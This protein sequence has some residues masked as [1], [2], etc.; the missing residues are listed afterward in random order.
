MRFVGLE[1]NCK[2][3]LDAVEPSPLSSKVKAERPKKK[4]TE[5]EEKLRRAESVSRSR[6]FEWLE[7]LRIAKFT[8]TRDADG[9]CGCGGGGGH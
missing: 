7:E 5:E 8:A 6:I 4:T 1:F 9:G 3:S 2:T